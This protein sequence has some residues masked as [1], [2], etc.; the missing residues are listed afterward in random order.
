MQ[1]ILQEGPLQWHN[2]RHSQGFTCCTPK[3][4]LDQMLR[5]VSDTVAYV[6]LSQVCVC[7]G[8]AEGSHKRGKHELHVIM[9]GWQ[10]ATG[11]CQSRLSR[12]TSAV[13]YNTMEASAAVWQPLA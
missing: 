13:V 2:N 1:V 8:A 10:A 5:R 3:L 6:H 12:I 7:Q 4:H 11:P 9:L